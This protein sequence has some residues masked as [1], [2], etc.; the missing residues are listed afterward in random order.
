MPAGQ[1]AAVQQQPRT[2]AGPD[3][4]PGRQLQWVR[5][6]GAGAGARGD[7]MHDLRLAWCAGRGSSMSSSIQ[8]SAAGERNSGRPARVEHDD[9]WAVDGRHEVLDLV[10]DQRPPG[11]GGDGTGQLGK[12]ADVV[13]GEPRLALIAEKP[14]CGP[15]DV[16]GDEGGAQFVAD[17]V[18]RVRAVPGAAR[19][20]A[21]GSDAGRSGT[22]PAMGEERPLV[23]VLDDVFVLG[24]PGSGAADVSVEAAGEQDGAGIHTVPAAAVEPDNAAQRV[25]DSAG[26]ADPAQAVRSQ[27]AD[28]RC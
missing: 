5:V 24:Q 14:G 22:A 28:L 1:E 16:V 17:A 12:Q 20:V 8:R 4:R 21:V 13:L 15:V 25:I 10:D 11:S 6:R 27:A 2:A 9:A 26:V 18:R 3:A 19:E 23:D 7:G